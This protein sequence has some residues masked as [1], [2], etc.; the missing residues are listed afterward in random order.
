MAKK[1]ATTKVAKVPEAPKVETAKDFVKISGP[2]QL[3][4]KLDVIYLKL[5]EISDKLKK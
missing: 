3:N 2:D 5:C 1:N 4:H